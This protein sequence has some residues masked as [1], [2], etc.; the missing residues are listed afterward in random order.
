MTA[1]TLCDEA[2]GSMQQDIGAKA[3]VAQALRRTP[4]RFPTANQVAAELHMTTRTLHRK[5]TR[6]GTSYQRMLD[7]IRRT[8]AIRYL[9]ETVISVSE[10]SDRL[11]YSTPT[12]FRQ[13]FR[14]WMGHAPNV[15]RLKA[16]GE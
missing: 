7:D 9:R 5:L 4:G 14:R 15:E 1:R 3:L 12:A 8:L 13:A 6:Q 11:N 16:R 10:I 2:L